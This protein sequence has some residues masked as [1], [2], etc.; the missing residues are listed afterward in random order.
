MGLQDDLDE[1]KLVKSQ[2]LNATRICNATLATCLG[3]TPT[4]MPSETQLPSSLNLDLSN[5]S[6]LDTLDDF[7][8]DEGVD[9]DFTGAIPGVWSEPEPCSCPPIWADITFLYFLLVEIGI[10]AVLIGI[11][12]CCKLIF[13]FAKR[14]SAA[15]K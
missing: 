12:L 2:L 15:G 6:K 5:N 10:F 1:C 13:L 14:S 3:L 7:W 8:G 4:T 11:C 9:S